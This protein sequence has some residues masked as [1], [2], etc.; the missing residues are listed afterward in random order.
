M[1]LGAAWKESSWARRSVGLSLE[2]C[3]AAGLPIQPPRTGAEKEWMGLSNTGMGKQ[4]KKGFY[5]KD[6]PLLLELY[7][8]TAGKESNVN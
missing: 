8:L 2:D 7:W 5:W 6:T 4:S 3:K 1:A